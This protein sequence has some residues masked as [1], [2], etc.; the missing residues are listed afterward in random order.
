MTHLE[1]IHRFHRLNCE[2]KDGILHVYDNF[3]AANI[4]FSITLPENLHIHGSCSGAFS[5][6]LKISNNMT[7]DRKLSLYCMSIDYLPKNLF[8]GGILDICGTS[9]KRVPDCTKM[10]ILVTTKPVTMN[11]ELQMKLVPQKKNNIKIINNPTE[12]AIALQKVLW[13]I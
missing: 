5:G 11:E 3:I 1:F 2:I 9:V 12:N 13:E 7:V 4:F 8:V 6:F 10:G